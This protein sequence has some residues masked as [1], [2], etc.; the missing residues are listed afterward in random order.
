MEPDRPRILDL[1][2]EYQITEFYDLADEGRWTDLPTSLTNWGD[3]GHQ[4]LKVAAYM[5]LHLEEHVLGAQVL[6]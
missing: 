5:G 6:P 2:E 4:V 1:L 3:G